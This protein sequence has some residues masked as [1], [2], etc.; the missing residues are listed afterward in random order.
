MKNKPLCLICEKGQLI[1]KMG[2]NLV[3]YKGVYQ[4][5]PLHYS[6]CNHCGSEQADASQVSLNK[7][8]M[9]KFKN[10]IDSSIRK[11]NENCK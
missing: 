6:V 3:S 5:L 4:T 7:T 1:H 11:E 2:S 10:H 8:I 9:D